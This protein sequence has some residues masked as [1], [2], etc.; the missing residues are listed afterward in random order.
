MA[1]LSSIFC[2]SFWTIKVKHDSFIVPPS[3]NRDGAVPLI[4]T[5]QNTEDQTPA[6]QLREFIS[7]GNSCAILWQLAVCET[8]TSLFQSTVVVAMHQ[9]YEDITH[10]YRHD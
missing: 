10:F 8:R 4:F 7:Y 6:R 9:L 1:L 3:P 5:V 2:N